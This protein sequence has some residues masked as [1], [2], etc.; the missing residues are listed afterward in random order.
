MRE[1]PRD[2][3]INKLEDLKREADGF[4]IHQGVK[5]SAYSV[6]L[7]NAIE[8]IKN[9]KLIITKKEGITNDNQNKA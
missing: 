3:V 9:S 1:M 4:Y 6:A 2:W 7:E 5:E 8:I